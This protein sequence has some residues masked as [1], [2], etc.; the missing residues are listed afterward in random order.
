M[1]FGGL[2]SLNLELCIS[3]ASNALSKSTHFLVDVRFDSMLDLEDCHK[4]LERF[5]RYDAK[6]PMS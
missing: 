1:C 5:P 4:G 3:I 2:C 6:K